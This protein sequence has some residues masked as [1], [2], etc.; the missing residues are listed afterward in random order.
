MAGVSGTQWGVIGTAQL[1]GCGLSRTTVMRWRRLGRLHPLLPGVDSVG[2]ACVP[3]E[4]HLV[5]ALI[6]AGPGAALSHAT[7]AWWWGLIPDRPARIEVSTLSR[8]RSIGPVA[9]HHPRQLEIVRHRRFAVTTVA[10]T[11]LDFAA[12]AGESQVRRALSEADYLGLLDLPALRATIGSGRRGSARLGRSLE[13]HDIRLA[14]TRSELERTFLALCEAHR[15]PLPEVNAR[16]GRMTVDA[17]WR[18]AGLVV[19]IDGH[20][21]HRSRAQVQR[22]RRRELHL[23]AAGLTVIRYAGDQV[24][25]EPALVAEDLRTALKPMAS[26]RADES[27]QR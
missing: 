6:H 13:R 17:L 25:G 11:L 1:R 4:G 18:Q 15:I 5:A 19:E 27:Y 12:A 26:G 9:V 14:R 8:A 10:R 24:V 2:H 23:R 22:D 3:V 7:A 16:V 21:G 20:R